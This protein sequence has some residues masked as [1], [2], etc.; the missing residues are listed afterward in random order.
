LNELVNDLVDGLPDCESTCASDASAYI[1]SAA[2]IS[3]VA[4]ISSVAYISNVAN[5]SNVDT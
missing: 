5:I 2:Y 4:Y 1:S 3:N